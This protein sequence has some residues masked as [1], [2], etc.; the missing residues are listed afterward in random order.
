[1]TQ[2]VF[3]NM[4]RIGKGFSDVDTPLFDEPIPLPPQAQTAQPS[5]PPPQQP[6]QTVDIS[7]YAMALFNTLLETCATLTKQVANLEQDKIAQAIESTKL[8]KRV[9][10]MHQNRVEITKLDANEDVTLE[11]VDAEVAMDADV[12][13]SMQDTDEAELAKVEEVI[14]VVTATKLMTEVIT[15]AD[16]TFTAAQV[17][18]A[19]APKRRRGVVIQDPKE[20]ATALVIAHSK[21]DVVDEVK[22]KE[23][24]D[25]TVMSTTIPFE[26]FWRKGDEEIEEEGSK[27]K[28]ESLNQDAT[29][30]QRIDKVTEELKTHLQIIANDDDD[31]Y[32]KAT[33][34]ALKLIQERFQSSEPK[35]F[36][37]DFLLNTLKIMFEKPN[38]EANI[39]R[40]QKGRYGLAKVKSWK[41]F[42]SYGV[43]N[44]TFTTT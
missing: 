17:P 36:S 25:N 14:E 7:Q 24:Q 6:S 37:D 22:R 30:K 8:K 4:G 13:G 32:T 16:T 40:D 5:S 31:V 15:T 41:L 10:R 35:N 34:L 44:I 43:H 9:R 11:D 23:K 26:L 20:T 29:K 3:G 28:G 2:K 42:E 19:S 18:K 27:I 21:N 12:Q 1:L 38:V 39:W 33:P